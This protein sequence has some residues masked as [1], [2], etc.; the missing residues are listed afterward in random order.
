[1][2]KIFSFFRIIIIKILAY[3][4]LL[5]AQERLK[6]EQLC[7]KSAQEILEINKA[8]IVAGR[9]APVEIIQSETAIANRQVSLVAA[10][11]TLESAKL[12]LLN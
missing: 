10:Q 6:I 3:R 7:L 2:L 4:N 5:R 1:M 9:L 8:L 12:A 11:N